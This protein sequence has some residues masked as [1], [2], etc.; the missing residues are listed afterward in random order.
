MTQQ[1][2]KIARV[3]NLAARFP[4]FLMAYK[5]LCSEF[6][7][8]HP[9]SHYP[10]PLSWPQR[11]HLTLFL[12]FGSQSRPHSHPMSDDFL[13]RL[14]SSSVTAGTSVT[15]GVDILQSKVQGIV[16]GFGV[17]ASSLD[18]GT[19]FR[20]EGRGR[21]GLVSHSRLDRVPV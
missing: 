11:R 3:D 12:S 16:T 6:H 5:H 21:R 19:S 9:G 1:K 18:P 15:S 20:F 4:L 13:F 7:L 2:L 14:F 8:H 10:C 17:D